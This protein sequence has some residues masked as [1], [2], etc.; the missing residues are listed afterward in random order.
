[1]TGEWKRQRRHNGPDIW[2]FA[3]HEYEAFPA[4]ALVTRKERIIAKIW[5][6]LQMPDNDL[7]Q[8]LEREYTPV[9]GLT[10][11]RIAP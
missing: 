3:N 5:G 7:Q 8:L 9:E 1:M 4:I 6:P 10:L 11:H 2:Q